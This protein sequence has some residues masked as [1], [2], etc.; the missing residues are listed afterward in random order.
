MPQRKKKRKEKK[1]EKKKGIVVFDQ[2]MAFPS[3][4]IL[5][6]TR[7]PSQPVAVLLSP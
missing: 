2:L 6:L 3:G 4:E 7:M 1:K 5:A